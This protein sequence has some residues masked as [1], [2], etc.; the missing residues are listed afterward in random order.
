MNTPRDTDAQAGP[1]RPAS[2]S[3]RLAWPTWMSGPDRASSRAAA[4]ADTAVLNR[5]DL[6]DALARD[7]PAR[8]RAAAH[9]RT[10]TQ[11]PTAPEGPRPA[12]GP[13]L[14]LVIFGLVIVAAMLVITMTWT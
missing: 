13:W 3:D 8:D 11:A 5:A 2:Q 1:D 4:E 9:R 10:R 7:H 14:A 6:V 12:T